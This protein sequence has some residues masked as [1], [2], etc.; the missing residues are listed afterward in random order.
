M[1]TC[2]SIHTC[3]A[4]F[5]I[6][7][8]FHVGAL[9]ALR[10][11]KANMDV[12]VSLGTNAAYAYSVISVLHRRSLHQ[13]GMDVNNMGFFETSALLITFISLGK[14]LEAHAKGKTSQVFA[15]TLISLRIKAV[16][17]VH[18]GCNRSHTLWQLHYIRRC[19]TM[20][21]IPLQCTTCS[22]LIISAYYWWQRMCAASSGYT[23]KEMLFCP[24]GSPIYWLLKCPIMFLSFRLGLFTAAALRDMCVAAGSD[25][26]AEADTIDSHAGDS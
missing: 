4:Q 14:Y 5:I 15:H 12:L 22:G 25:G 19:I 7:W 3:C 17:Y 24:R 6:G 9:R 18:C 20:K 1:R 13:Q 11:G 23:C 16:L 21:V 8:H 26:A 10:R 2:P